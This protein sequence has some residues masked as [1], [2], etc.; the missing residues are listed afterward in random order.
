MSGGGGRME[1]QGGGNTRTA[2][3]PA[4]DADV[5]EHVPSRT[6][7]RLFP[8]PLSE[9]EKKR[10]TERSSR[11]IA[12]P[13]SVGFFCILRSSRGIERRKNKGEA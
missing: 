4:G 12:F 13:P 10:R 11:H 1:E 7:A 5:V 3:V 6:P 8:P 9:E 2:T